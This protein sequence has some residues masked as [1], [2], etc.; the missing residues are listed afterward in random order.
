MYQPVIDR[1]TAEGYRCLAPLQRGYSPGARP[2]RRRDY[3][4]DDLVDDVLTL[5]D[6]SGAERVHLV[7]HDWGAAV[8]WYVA[9]GFP[10][11][12]LT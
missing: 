5:I 1:L 7:G 12:L 11:R 10:E 6:A 3:R 8:A 2:K 4:A 9:Q